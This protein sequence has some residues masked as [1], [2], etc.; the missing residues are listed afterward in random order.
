M[1]QHDTNDTIIVQTLSTI[2]LVI[3]F[4][5]AANMFKLGYP[6]RHSGLE[7]SVVQGIVTGK[8]RGKSRQTWVND[9]TYVLGKIATGSRIAEGRYQCRRALHAT[10]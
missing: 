6:T 4:C 3:Q 8:S 5:N 1:L 7:K 10:S 9:I 2:K